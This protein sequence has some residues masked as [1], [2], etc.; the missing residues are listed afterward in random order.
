MLNQM[1]HHGIRIDVDYL[2]KLSVEIHS[3]LHDEEGALKFLVGHEI[4]YNSQPVVAKV[5]FED[6]RVQGSDMVPRTASGGMSTDEDVL[7]MY[8]SHPVVS[9]ILECRGLSKLLSTYV[10]K[11]PLMVDAHGRI[12]TTFRNTQART[13]RLT[14]ENPNLQ[15]I[16]IKGD[17]GP[18]IRKAFIAALGHVLGSVDLSQIEMRVLAHCSEDENL[19]LIFRNGQDI[20]VMTAAEVFNIPIEQVDKHKH[21]L[22]CK[23]VNF[24]IVYGE[25]A[26]GLQKSIASIGGPVYTVPE[27]DAFLVRYFEHRQG[28]KRYMLLTETRAAR[29]GC[30][31]DMFGRMRPIPE[32]HSAVPRIRSAGLRQ[33]VNHP[34]QSGA[35]GI[36]KLSMAEI[37]ELLVPHYQSFS[38]EICWPLLQIH[39]H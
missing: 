33:A 28:I 27:M 31:W 36:L 1:H 13:G 15:N 11:L 2:A 21:R 25:T 16:P 34:I 38:G 12:H 3:A 26:I 24:G 23:S 6:F 10:D 19:I 17:W 37:D 29:H 18:K 32:A 14:S 35:Q 39:D 4:N 20:H 5:L 7:S 9:Q 8:A 30:S 22:V